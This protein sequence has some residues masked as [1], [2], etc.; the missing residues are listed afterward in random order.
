MILFND[1]Q[2][3]EPGNETIMK[4]ILSVAEACDFLRVSKP[5]LYRYL[6]TGIIPALKVGG[7]WRFH[8]ELLGKWIESQITEGTAARKRIS[9][10]KTMLRRIKNDN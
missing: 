6:R 8:K 1:L 2:A 9:I 7:A 5:T 3:Y 10:K 4:E